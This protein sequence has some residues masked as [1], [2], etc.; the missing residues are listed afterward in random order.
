MR[1]VGDFIGRK[2]SG[3]VPGIMFSAGGNISAEVFGKE[4]IIAAEAAYPIRY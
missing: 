3:R 2:F 4:K 1:R